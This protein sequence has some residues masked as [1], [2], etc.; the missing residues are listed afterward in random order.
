MMYNSLTDIPMDSHGKA[1]LVTK[2]VDKC[3]TNNVRYNE[4]LRIIQLKSPLGRINIVQI[5]APT[6]KKKTTR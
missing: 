5:Y 2:E 4:K 6:T 1:S 3:I